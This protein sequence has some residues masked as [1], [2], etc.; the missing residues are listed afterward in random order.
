MLEL[1]FSTKD[2]RGVCEDD[3]KARE[4]FGEAP[5]EALLRRLADLRAAES[6]RDILV[7]NLRP[8][9]ESQDGMVQILDLEDGWVLTIRPSHKRVPYSDGVV[10]WTRVSRVQ[11]VDIHRT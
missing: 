8:D 5:T 9:Q 10:D 4:Q 7:G 3:T 2:I 1:S 11:I 6:I